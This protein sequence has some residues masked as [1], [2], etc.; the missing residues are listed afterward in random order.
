MGSLGE[1]LVE[2]LKWWCLHFGVISL[3]ALWRN[4]WRKERHQM[5]V[6]GEVKEPVWEVFARR[7]W[8]QGLSE[9]LGGQWGNAYI[10]DLFSGSTHGTQAER[11]DD[12]GLPILTGG[13]CVLNLRRGKIQG[14]PAP[15][16]VR[17]FHPRA[18]YTTLSS[19]GKGNKKK[20][21]TENI[22]PDTWRKCKF[23]RKI[24]AIWSKSLGRWS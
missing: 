23:P 24:F 5:T 9:R 1:V 20:M 10:L 18:H 3:A 12:Q 11:R 7:K 19:H 6:G 16:T 21:E 8:G 15:Q 14:N 4:S 22:L 2:K 13:V 17:D